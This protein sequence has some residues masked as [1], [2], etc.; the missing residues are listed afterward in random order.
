MAVDRARALAMLPEPYALALR[1]SDAGVDAPAIARRVG[2]DAWAFPTFMRL[3]RA[4]LAALLT[5][6]NGEGSWSR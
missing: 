1:L 3:A 4:K 6:E 5:S 2:V